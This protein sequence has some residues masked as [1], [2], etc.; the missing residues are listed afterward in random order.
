[1]RGKGR[2]RGRKKGYLARVGL[3]AVLALLVM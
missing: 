3:S 1:M 2:G